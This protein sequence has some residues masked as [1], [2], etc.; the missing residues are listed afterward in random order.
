MN[1]T[2]KTALEIAESVRQLLQSRQLLAGQVLPPVRELALALEVNRNTVAAAY[3][4]LTAAGLTLTQ[5]RLG[6]SIRHQPEAGEQEGMLAGSPLIDLACGNPNQ[7]WLPDPA[8]LLASATYRPRLYGEATVTPALE[9]HARQWLAG[10]CPAACDIDVTHGAVDAIERLLAAHLVAGD[11]VAVE[12][13]CFL[14]SINT[15]RLG[16]LQALGVAMDQHGML[17]QALEQALQQGA[18]AVLI[19]PRAHNPTGCSLS[20]ARAAALQQI[21]ARHPHVLA[22]VDDHFAMLALAP[23]YSVL[24]AATRHWAVIRSVSK[25]FG[26]DLRL[27]CVA[28]DSETARRLR[29]RLAPGTTW[30]SHLLQEAVAACFASREIQGQVALAKADYAQRSAWL[31]E[32]LR[33]QGIGTPADSDGLNLW[34]PLRQD[35]QSLVL[36]MAN[37]GWLVRSGAAFSVQEPVQGLR[38]SIATMTREL[39]WRFAADLKPGIEGR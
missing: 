35:S 39:A 29:L 18:R 27:A 12:H 36:M 30:V 6:T 24:P 10:D 17:P 26:P 19:T 34:L 15:L 4:R 20:Q 2:G 21:L 28:S 5:G 25:V 3:K 16:G 9:Q 23:Y 1:I 22:I 33:E 13:P 37:K 11:K 32:A 31:A 7:T 38:I 8:A 14:S